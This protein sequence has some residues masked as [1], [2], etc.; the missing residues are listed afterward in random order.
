MSSPSRSAPRAAGSTTGSRPPMCSTRG[1]PCSSPKRERS[2]KAGAIDFRDSLIKRALEHRDTITVGRT[3]GVHAEPTTFGLRLAGFAFEAD[4]NLGRLRS[5][6]EGAAIGKLSGAV[7]T[8]ASV[9]PAIERRVM[10][11]LGLARRADL[12]PGRA[13]RPPRRGDAGD[14]PRGRRAGALRDRGP[15]PAAHRGARGG[16]AVRRGSEGLLGDAAQAQPDP[17]GANLRAGPRAAWLRPGGGRERRPVARA[18]HLSLGRRAGDP[19]RRDDPARLHAAPRRSRR[20]GDDRPRRPHARQPRAHAR[21]A[22]QPARPHR[23]GRVGNVARRRVPDR[24]GNRRSARGTRRR[25]SAS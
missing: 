7:G 4:R 16:G 11:A 25:P 10:E 21:R 22:A 1:S 17:L 12:D 2:S 6:F 18:R 8:Y 9:P 23:P 13:A 24:A 19:A 3:H 5:A 15:Q 14:R 20:G